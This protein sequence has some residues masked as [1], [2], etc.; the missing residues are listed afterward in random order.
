MGKIINL[1]SR[2]N[3]TTNVNVPIYHSL[4]FSLGFISNLYSLDKND[5]SN[6][7]LSKTLEQ[8]M[9][10]SENEE[11]IEELLDNKVFYWD[12]KI[13]QRSVPVDNNLYENLVVN[14]DKYLLH[15]LGYFSEYFKSNEDVL[16]YSFEYIVQSFLDSYNQRE[17]SISIEFTSRSKLVEKYWPNRKEFEDKFNF[18]KNYRYIAGFAGNS[19]VATNQKKALEL[20]I[21]KNSQ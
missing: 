16:A 1:F 18:L 2:N 19:P 3:E 14:V 11:A 17:N 12:Y 13:E 7:L 9:N 4:D 6:Y 5:F 20:V 21:Q 10:I 15:N 8:F